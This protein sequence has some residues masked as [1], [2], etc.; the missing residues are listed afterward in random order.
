MLAA[1]TAA[2]A[3][4]RPAIDLSAMPDNIMENKISVDS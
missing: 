1:K 4:S 3:R 2:A